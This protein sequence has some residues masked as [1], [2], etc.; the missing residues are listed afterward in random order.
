MLGHADTFILMAF[1]CEIFL[2]LL[3]EPELFWSDDWNLFDFFVTFAS[4]VPEVFNLVLGEAR[5]PTMKNIS[6]LLGR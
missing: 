6:S 3:D 2:K 1:A 5:S 4:V